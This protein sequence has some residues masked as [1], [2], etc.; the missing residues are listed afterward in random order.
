MGTEKRK[1]WSPPWGYPEAAAVAGGAVLA[2]FLVEI[3]TAGRGVTLPAA[4]I[5]QAIFASLLAGV[6]VG[7]LVFRKRPLVAWLASVPT[8]LTAMSGFAALVLLMGVFP[9]TDRPGSFL[10]AVGLTHVFRSW[11]F[12]LAAV[13]LLLSLGLTA[14]RGARSLRLRGISFFLNHAGLWVAVC[15]GL[16]GA[17]DLRRVTVA[18]RTGE[19]VWTGVAEGHRSVE[20]PFALELQRFTLE[21]YP[22]RL[23]LARSGGD[24][25]VTPGRDAVTAGARLLADGRRVTVV[26]CHPEAFPVG[27]GY[28]PCPR[29]GACPAALVEVAGEGGRAFRGWIASGSSWQPPRTLALSRGVELGLTAP[30][31]RRYRS[32]FRVYTPDQ[33]VRDVDIEV[34]R[35]ADINGWKVYQTGYDERMGRWSEWSVV[36]AVRDPWLPLVYL[37]VFMMFGGAALLFW[38][39]R[40]R[41]GEA[42]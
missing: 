10:T 33:R 20:L 29:P 14:F 26:A 18:C 8:A 22:P 34:N 2:G 21:T 17:G 41:G 30:A 15:A 12:A 4:P 13:F 28:R 9:Q 35:P 31:A 36:E 42:S 1:T 38:T 39:G 7:G 5:S 25:P 32:A 11:P 16:L 37:G 27:D 24:R 3:A 40:G 23:F 19:T 6:A